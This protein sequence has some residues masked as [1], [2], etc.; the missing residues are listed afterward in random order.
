VA[1][2]NE[3][4]NVWTKISK[5]VRTVGLSIE[6]FLLLTT[7][8]LAYSWCQYDVSVDIIKCIAPFYSRFLKGADVDINRTELRN[9]N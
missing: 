6:K 5:R 4:Q 8:E 7:N 3:E 1:L 2:W 9:K